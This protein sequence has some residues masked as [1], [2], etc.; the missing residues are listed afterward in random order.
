M[1]K[2][3]LE[4]IAG[5]EDEIRQ[6]E[7]QR[8]Q[9]MQQQKADERKARTKRLIERGAILESFIPNPENL[10]NEQIK[11]FL[12]KTVTSD[13]ARRALASV[14]AEPR[15]TA[16]EKPTGAEQNSGTASG[17]SAANPIKQA[18]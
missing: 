3:K 14:T 17:T 11:T 12:E 2:T 13:Y 16:P 10:T 9:L 7:N 5:L 8:R 6:L 4:K 15:E 18:V 1:G